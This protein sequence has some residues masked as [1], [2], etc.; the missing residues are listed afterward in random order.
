M[1]T[2]S[3]P[4]TFAAEGPEGKGELTSCPAFLQSSVKGVGAETR[5]LWQVKGPS[6][7]ELS[8]GSEHLRVVVLLF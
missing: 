3:V 6:R 1:R 8:L 5:A 4:H 2:A 7:T